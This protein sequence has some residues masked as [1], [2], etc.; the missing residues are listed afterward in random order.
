MFIYISVYLGPISL[1][2]ISGIQRNGLL[3]VDNRISEP[4]N[5]TFLLT[6]GF[7]PKASQLPQFFAD[8]FKQQNIIG[9]PESI[10]MEVLQYLRRGNQKHGVAHVPGECG[11]ALLT[12]NGIIYYSMISPY[13]VK[14]GRC[15]CF[16]FLTVG[17]LARDDVINIAGIA[18]F[19]L[20]PAAWIAPSRTGENLVHLFSGHVFKF[21]GFQLL[22]IQRTNEHQIDQLLNPCQRVG[23]TACP[24]IRPDFIH[25]ILMAPV[26]IHLSFVRM[27]GNKFGGIAAF[28]SA[29]RD[30][31]FARL[32]PDRGRHIMPFLLLTG[33]ACFTKGG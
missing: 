14:S 12:A 18:V 13:F 2:V 9:I 21:F 5:N 15:P 6:I 1:K 16:I 8:F 24:D 31:F 23:D 27:F 10:C 26:I 28:Y 4:G 22:L 33:F 7:I 32:C 11:V 17:N 29:R 30:T 3:P 20:A 25:L 19:K